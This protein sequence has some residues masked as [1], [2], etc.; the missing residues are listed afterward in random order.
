VTITGAGRQGG[1]G[2]NTSQLALTV[3]LGA[4]IWVSALALAVSLCMAAKGGDQ[5][6]HTRYAPG[7][8]SDSPRHEAEVFARIRER[9]AQDAVVFDLTSR[10]GARTT[11]R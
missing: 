2:V 8:E 9:M 7:E 3:I 5:A 10:T 4:G 11:R 6:L 1:I